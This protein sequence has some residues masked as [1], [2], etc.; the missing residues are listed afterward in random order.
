MFP[1]EHRTAA[2][3][4]QLAAAFAALA[5]VTADAGADA[6]EGAFSG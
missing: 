5:T 6:G 2:A 4:I 1:D 3:W